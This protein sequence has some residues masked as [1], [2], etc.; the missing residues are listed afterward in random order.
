MALMSYEFIEPDNTNENL[1]ESEEYLQ[2]IPGCTYHMSF[3]IKRDSTDTDT[4]AFYIAI[5]PYDVNKK[6]IYCY[7]VYLISNTET[8]LASDLKY[9]D[10]AVALTDGTNWKADTN[11]RV[12][13]VCN[14]EYGYNFTDACS[15]I[16]QGGVSG[17]TI[18]LAS[19]W[20]GST[21]TAGTKV[22]EFT[23]GGTYYYPYSWSNS[24]TNWQ[25]NDWWHIEL[26]FSFPISAGNRFYTAKYFKVP[27][28]LSYQHKFEVKNKVLYN[29]SIIQDAY[30]AAVNPKVY[31]NGTF[32]GKIEECY[33]NQTQFG[34]YLNE[35]SEFIE[36]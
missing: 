29:K 35:S 19:A 31:K 3:D 8:T 20:S 36:I 21:I 10:T 28:F 2:V 5:N 32:D 15:T 14:T 18:T 11:Y 25:S 34:K 13:G 17:N 33:N 12:F 4:N 16:K 9:G 26:D 22:R 23:D 24:N 1:W 7:Q 6:F 27:W 30:T